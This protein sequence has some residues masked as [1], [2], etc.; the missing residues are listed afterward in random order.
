MR[1]LSRPLGAKIL[2][3]PAL[4]RPLPVT[5]SRVLAYDEVLACTGSPGSSGSFAFVRDVEHWHLSVHYIFCRLGCVASTGG[6]TNESDKQG[7]AHLPLQ[8]A[9][10]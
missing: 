9:E 8:P 5:A 7:I 10:D 3:R 6:I 4:R 2:L 1:L